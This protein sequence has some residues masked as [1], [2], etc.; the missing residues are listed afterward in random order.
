VRKEHGYGKIWIHKITNKL[1]RLTSSMD[2]G[3]D[4]MLVKLKIEAKWEVLV[5][6]EKK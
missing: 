5:T 1:S 2:S 6:H 4:C 3:S